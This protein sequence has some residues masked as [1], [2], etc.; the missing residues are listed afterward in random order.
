MGKEEEKDEAIAAEKDIQVMAEK[1]L[2]EINLGSDSQEPRPISISANLT[3]NEKLELILLLKEFKDIF[4]WNYSEMS[5]LDPGLVAHTLNIDPEVKS[6]ARPARIFH[7]EI[8]GQIVKIVQK[9]LA[10]GFIKPIQ[11]SRWLSN[12]APAKKKNGQIR[13]YI[14]FRNLNKAC[15][16][17]E[18]PLPNMDLLIDSAIGSVM[19]LFM[20]SFNEYNQIKMAPK[21]TKKTAFRTPMG[22]FYYSVMPFGLKNVGA[23]YQ[24][25]MTAI[26]HDMMHQELEDY[27]DDIVVK[28]RRR[29]E[30][31]RVLKRVFERCRAFKLIINP[32]KCAFEVFSKKFLGFL[33]HNKGIGVDPVK[34][35]AIAIIRPPATV[36]ELKSFLGKV[37]YIQ[38]FIPGLASITS[39]F[40]KLLKKG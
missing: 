14:D 3:K 18:F 11:H 21:D 35:T 27:V 37:S 15:P 20:D 40:T 23:T 13:D 22:N 17:D 10:A 9:L 38:R 29:E 7:T 34:T 1:E 16:K 39:A 2:E 24:R 8:E 4:A 36:K 30:H 19:F 33:V 28:S 26:F 5:G 12:I 31:F 6:V 32:L 25:A